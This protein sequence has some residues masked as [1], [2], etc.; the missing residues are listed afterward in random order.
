[1][2]YF[3]TKEDFKK[4]RFLIQ[5][6]DN[7]CP[8]NLQEYIDGE[9][10]TVLKDL[11]GVEMY[12]DFVNDYVNESTQGTAGQVYIGNTFDN[13]FY[14]I[15]YDEIELECAC[16]TCK[17]QSSRN[18]GLVDMLKGFIYFAYMRDFSNIQRTLQG[19]KYN[20][21]ESSTIAPMSNVGLHTYYNNS[22]DD[23]KVIE[24]YILKNRKDYPMFCGR[25]RTHMGAF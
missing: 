7:I 21:A 17:C 13:P 11:F 18:D 9:E 10:T 6:N 5:H 12:N 3:V 22:V 16:K 20:N 4:G 23:Y 25:T 8:D 1:M 24:K 19:Y 2:A 14:K 15:L